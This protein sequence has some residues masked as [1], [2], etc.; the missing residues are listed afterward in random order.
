SAEGYSVPI[1]LRIAGSMILG[2]HSGNFAKATVKQFAE[3][4]RKI[5]VIASPA[6]YLQE[7]LVELGA[8]SVRVIPN[9]VDLDKFAPRRKNRALLESLQIDPSEIVLA[10]MS[11]FKSMK[12]VPDIVYSA[13]QVLER[14]PNVTYL[15]LGDG[16]TCPDTKQICKKLGIDRRFRFA[17]WVD[18]SR[19]PEYFNLA[20]IVV[21]PSEYECQSRVYLET[22]AS[23]RV[24]VASNIAGARE[25]IEDGQSG[26]LFS[27]NCCQEL[28][29]KI[30]SI[31]NNPVLQ[32]KLGRKARQSVRRH[33][34]KL[35][36]SAYI[37]MF[38]EALAA[39]DSGS[40]H[41]VHPNVF[42]RL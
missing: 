22:Q 20:D 11:N 2:I 5:E 6:G 32:S 3:Y 23:G 19:I 33:D 27:S 24:I 14:C 17:N 37:S 8:R 18:Y 1:V 28:S 10:H 16:E 40:G 31:V 30:V 25:V 36:S 29:D 38:R 7:K 21:M 42:N 4:L 39:R 35:I 12:R 15:I 9:P 26:V 34:A 41:T 13:R